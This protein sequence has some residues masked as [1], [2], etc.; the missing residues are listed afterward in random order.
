MT[1]ENIMQEKYKERLERM[2]KNTWKILHIAWKKVWG[3]QLK[4]IEFFVRPSN[5]IYGSWRRLTATYSS[6]LL[7]L[8]WPITRIYISNKCIL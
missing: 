1:Q 3:F 5:I 6:S 2:L 7:W 4:I 8:L